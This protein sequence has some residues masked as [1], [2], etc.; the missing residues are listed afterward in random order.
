MWVL[1]SCSGMR[2]LLIE[3]SRPA[4]DMLPDGIRSLTLMNRSMSPDYDNM[5]ADSLQALFYSKR[6]RASAWI[7]D[8]LAADTVLLSL[9]DL[10]YSSGRYDVVVPQMRNI[11]RLRNF[12]VTP[13]PLFWSE[14]R[15]I[16]DEF[17]TDA[18]LV[19]ETYY[20]KITANCKTF[21]NY[22]GAATVMAGIESQYKAVVRIYDPKQE[23]IIRQIVVS[24]TLVWEERTPV[25][26]EITVGGNGFGITLP[27]IPGTAELNSALSRTIWRLPAIK[28]CVIESAIDAALA[29][30]G[31]LSPEW[32]RETRKYFLLKNEDSMVQEWASTGNWQAAFD[33]WRPYSTQGSNAVRAKALFNMALATEMLDDVDAAINL[34]RQSM[35]TNVSR[36]AEQYIRQLESRK[37]I[38]EQYKANK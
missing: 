30:D 12:D 29:I 20:G 7:L 27:V 21:N 16:C 34:A 35:D 25:G 23:A 14:V 5:N 10:L 17:K 32:G 9:G 13:T 28:Q 1:A 3:T 22:S 36:H 6:F 31:H 2:S 15:Q 33:F 18:L 8:S 26:G 4:A 19:L 37:A 24:D 38:I 11:L